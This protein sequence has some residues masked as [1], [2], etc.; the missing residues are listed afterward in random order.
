MPAGTLQ[1]IVTC[2]TIGTVNSGIC[3]PGQKLQLVQGYVIDVPAQTFFDSMYDNSSMIN[4]L[5]SGG[6]D[7][8]AALIGFAGVVSV[9]VVG[10]SAGVVVNTV[11]KAGGR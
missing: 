7:A 3:P 11:R 8:D 2:S 1:S 10:L 9:F 4:L 6:F 5:L